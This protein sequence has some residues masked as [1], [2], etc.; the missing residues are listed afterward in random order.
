MILA[1]G[2]GRRLR[3]FTDKIP[4]PLISIKG[5]P[6]IIHHIYRLVDMGVKSIVI[7][8]GWLGDV[9][10]SSVGYGSQWGVT[11]T[12]S[13][14]RRNARGILGTAAGIRFAIQN[15]LLTEDTFFVINADVWTDFCQWDEC[16]LT[17]NSRVV[18]HLLLVPKSTDRGKGDFS[19][20]S[21]G[22]I[23]CDNSNPYIFSGM[24]FYRKSVFQ[25]KDPIF[26]HLGDMLRYYAYKGMVSGSLYPGVWQDMGTIERIRGID[27]SFDM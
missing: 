17:E 18:S 2:R 11:I 23:D 1:A 4:K 14:E 12:Y 5:K 21:S 16:A 27:S 19:L 9:L 8:T 13:R 6:L 3:P 7:N 24:G 22:L 20:K 10:E 15:N 25:T 26:R